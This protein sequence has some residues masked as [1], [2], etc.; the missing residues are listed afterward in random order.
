MQ[1]ELRVVAY[2]VDGIEYFIATNRLDLA[3]DDI[4]RTYKTPRGDW[5]V[6]CLVETASE[7]LSFTDATACR[8][9]YLSA[10]GNLLS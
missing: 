6:L 9:D 7:G 4:A 8:T 2:L 10:A 5:E 1:Q 3:A